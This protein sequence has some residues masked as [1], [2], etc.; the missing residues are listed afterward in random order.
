MSSLD[1]E[2]DDGRA[3]VIPV[4]AVDAGAVPGSPVVLARP[5]ARVPPHQVRRQVDVCQPALFV[6]EHAGALDRHKH[7]RA[8]VVVC[9]GT[10]VI[11]APCSRVNRAGPWTRFTPETR[12]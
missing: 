2:C 1:V 10:P 7:V 6:E 11:H 5:A 9:G 3:P 4:L 12:N 8:A